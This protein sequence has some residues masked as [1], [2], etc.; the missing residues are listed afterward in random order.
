VLCCVAASTALAIRYGWTRSSDPLDQVIFAG[1]AGALDLFKTSLPTTATMLWAD[2]ER[3]KAR[4]AWAGFVFLTCL[5]LW[6]AFGM[7][8]TQLAE[9]V[10]AQLVA[11]ST[12]D[13]RKAELDRLTRD[14][15]ELPKFQPRT[16]TAR[17]ACAGALVGFRR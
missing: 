14:R 7:S 3:A 12:Y 10:T 1:A 15:A 4:W 5:S 2:A 6:C 13:E 8:A 17:S 16:E 9:K 11:K